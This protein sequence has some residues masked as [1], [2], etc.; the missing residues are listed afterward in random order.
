MIEKLIE[1]HRRRILNSAHKLKDLEVYK[2]VYIFSDRTAEQQ[3]KKNDRVQRG[4]LKEL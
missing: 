2:Q 4:R 3:K 1:K